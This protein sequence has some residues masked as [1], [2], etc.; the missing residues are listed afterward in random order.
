V[1][2]PEPLTRLLKINV[3]Y[4]PLS[5]KLYKVIEVWSVDER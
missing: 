5:H 4:E 1:D 3:E 2:C